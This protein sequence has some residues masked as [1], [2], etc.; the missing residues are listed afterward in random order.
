[1]AA[2]WIDAI[3]LS[4]ILALALVYVFVCDRWPSVER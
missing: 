2:S 1:M 3:G 4:S